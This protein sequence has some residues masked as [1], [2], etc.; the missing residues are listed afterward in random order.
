M[1]SADL[2]ERAAAV[3]QVLVDDLESP[4]VSDADEHHLAKVLRIRNGESVVATDGRGSWRM[5]S[6]NYGLQPVAAVEFEEPTAPTEIAFALTK[7]DKPEWTV[8]KLTEIG[9]AYI[10]PMSSE[11]TIV[12][13]DE[14]KKEK[15]VARFRRIAQE[16]SM[17]SR[18]VWLPV[19]RDFATFDE[20]VS[21][22]FALAAP[23]DDNA[24]PNVDKIAI[25]P[26]GGWTDA[27]LQRARALVS[28]GSTIL[29]AETAAL[30][31]AARLHHQP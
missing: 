30:V 2:L 12:K 1:P 3:A 6:W 27:E 25:G 29:R 14:R 17:Q 16:A 13:W 22:G 8:Q 28:L 23:G 15:H 24:T 5:C 18:R 10:T 9:V 11:R 20:I 4:A 21:R 31:A 26:E 7:G 19:V